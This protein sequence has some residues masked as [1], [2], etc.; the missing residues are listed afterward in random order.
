[1]K[2]RIQTHAGATNSP[3]VVCLTSLRA[4]RTRLRTLVRELTAGLTPHEQGELLRLLAKLG[5][6][7]PAPEPVPVRIRSR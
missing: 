5:E 4:V 1:V 3:A 7:V 2:P 6:G